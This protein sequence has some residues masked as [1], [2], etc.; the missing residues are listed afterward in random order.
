MGDMKDEGFFTPHGANPLLRSMMHASLSLMLAAPMMGCG[1]SS[2]LA[3]GTRIQAPRAASIAFAPGAVTTE[4]PFTR[5]FTVDAEGE[6][7]LELR[8]RV[9]GGDWGLAGREAATLRVSVD[10][11]YNQDIVLTMGE[12]AHTYQVSMG[13]LKPGV[14]TLQFDRFAPFSAPGLTQVAV[15]GAVVSV[16][17]PDSPAYDALAN[18]PILVSREAPHRTDALLLMYY[19]VTAHPDGRSTLRYTPVFS[20]EDGGTATRALMARWGR[21]VDIDW[22][23]A[24][25]R[26]RDGKIEDESYQAWLHMT[27][28]FKGKRD[29]RHPFLQIASNNNIFSDSIDGPLRLRPAPVMRF[30]HGAYARE[31]V[32]DRFPWTYQL[33]VKELFRERKSAPD[34][35]KQPALLGDAIGDPRRFVFVEFKQDSG[36]RGVAAG[37]KLKHMP[38]VFASN[39]G[40]KGL[41]AERDGWCRVAVE[42][43]RAVT[44]DDIERLELFGLGRGDARVTAVRKVVVLDA[45][46]QPQF[47]P[48]TWEGE[49]E[50]RR[51]EDRVTVY[52]IKPI[53]PADRPQ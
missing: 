16:V 52:G 17:T 34:F 7:L 50:L 26:D 14:H 42:L 39:R 47:L 2:V 30:E 22:A 36:G 27:R 6:G 5:T 37:I 1:T 15:E 13:A 28:R 48:I 43:P 3:Q 32:L 8:A 11:V 49:G 31:E 21:T 38:D 51:D 35:Y 53:P 46:Y 20:N 4:S 40:D 45:D 33:M 10:G 44:V 9:P 18:A 19:E 23:F 24:Q 41:Q 12:T 25:R 29:G